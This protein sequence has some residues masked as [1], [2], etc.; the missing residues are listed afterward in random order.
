MGL[1]GKA[2]NKLKIIFQDIKFQHSIFAL[3]FALMSTFLAAQN[4]PPLGKLLWIIVAMIAARS[5]AMAFNRIVDCKYDRLNPRTKAW[6]LPSGQ[7]NLW[8]YCLFLV[9]NLAVFLFA[10]HQLNT[11]AFKLSPLAIAII[12]F[13]SF[14]KRFTYWSH[15]FLGLALGIAPIG[16]WIGIREEISLEALILSGAVL[17]WTAG[18]DILY[19]CQ[20]IIF[21]KQQGLYSWPVKYGIARSLIFAR[22]LHVG[23]VLLLLLLA[24]IAPLRYFYLVGVLLV[25]IMLAYEHSLVKS[26]D[27][28]R[29][30]TA[31]FTMNGAISLALMLFTLVDLI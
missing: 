11:L 28:S 16:A 19:G 7:I 15:F 31:F 27:L 12:F 3:P 6:A 10:C 25:A 13:Y 5:S 22:W 26:H 20:D 17:L 24:F 8:Q 23:M 1:V 14:T 29:L 2:T 4:F 21:D 18:F 9:S 30:N